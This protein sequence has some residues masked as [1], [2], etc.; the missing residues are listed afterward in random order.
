MQSFKYEARD[1]ATGKKITAQIQGANIQSVV[2]VV[3][4]QGLTVVDV[5][6]VDGDNSGLISRFTNRITTKDKVLFSRQL[7][8]LINAGLPI[9]QSLRNV[10]GQT[11]NKAL[12]AVIS[13]I[14]TDVEAGSAFSQALAKHPKVFNEIFVSLVASGEASGTLD[15]A[16]ERIANQQEKDAEIMS[17]IR[18]AMVYPAV[19]IAVMIVVVGFMVVAVL[20][21]VEQIYKDLPGA[22]LP[23]ITKILLAVSHF[24]IDYWWVALILLGL[25]IFFGSRWA[26][27]IGGKEVI[28]KAK[29]RAPLFGPLFMKVYMARFARTGATL[30]TSGV[31]LIQILEIV[32]RAVNNVHIERSIRKAIEK[33]KGGKSLSESLTGDPNFLQLV[34]DMIHIGEESGSLEDM[35]EKTA[36]YYEKEVDNQIKTISTI[37]EPL[38]MVLLGVVAFGIV[39]AVLLPVYGLVNQNNLGR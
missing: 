3:K 6:P 25:S 20:P 18:G 5:T 19:V 24:V 7:S 34:P 28:D 23:L 29:M 13:N 39:A 22:S 32:A 35:L 11:Q 30:V 10:Q 26:R 14:I 27:S 4:Q 8:T 15:K 1:P 2:N 36:D 31:P 17:K 16:L 37:I 21:Q 38:L 33:V 9:V 12:Q